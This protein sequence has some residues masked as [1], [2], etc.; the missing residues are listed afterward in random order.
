MKNS[1]KNR[2]HQTAYEAPELEG[3]FL[4]E[5]ADS[6]LSVSDSL[7]NL[8]SRTTND[9]DPFMLEEF[10]EDQGA[11]YSRPLETPDDAPKRAGASGKIK[12]RVSA[13]AIR[14]NKKAQYNP[15]VS[16]RSRSVEVQEETYLDL[17]QPYINSIKAKPYL[18]LF[19]A[20]VAGVALARAINTSPN[21]R[22]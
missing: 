10:N 8:S 18:V 16:G 22:N 20:L 13:E 7:G 12:R 21:H 1:S 15:D 4:N 2:R 9:I 6:M 14:D 3:E 5:S 17:L 11:R 19:G